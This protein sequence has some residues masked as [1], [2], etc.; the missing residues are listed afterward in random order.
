MRGAAGSPWR[1]N[2]R[3]PAAGCARGPSQHL[4]P[5]GRGGLGV[6]APQATQQAREVR[7]VQP[8]VRLVAYTKDPFQ[9]AVASARTC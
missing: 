5:L 3:R 8:R 7:A 2:P 1:R 6:G 9:L 4:H